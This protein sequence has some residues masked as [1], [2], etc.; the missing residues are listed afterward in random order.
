MPTIFLLALVAI[1]LILQAK[2]KSLEGLKYKYELSQNL[3][4]PDEI[5]ILITSLSNHSLR[6]IPFVKMEEA[7]PTGK[8]LNSTVYLMPRSKLVRKAPIS[9]PT[10]GRYLFTG[11]ILRGGDFLGLRE[12][13]QEVESPNELIVYPKPSEETQINK[14]ISGFL[15]DIS[16]RRFIIE[17]PI[18]TVGF[19]EYSGREPMKAISWPQS[20]RS[21]QLMVKTYD[22]SSELSASVVL[23][24]EHDRPESIENCLSIAHQVCLILEKQKVKY[25]FYSNILPE[26]ANN[27]WA[28]ISAG[29]GQG[30]LR[31]ILEGL[32]RA[33]HYASEPSDKL[34]ERVKKKESMIFITPKSE[35]GIIFKI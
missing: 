14:L 29:L 33:T 17:D 24:V 26:G 23:D 28:Y 16:V 11:A 12:S 8:T 5:F 21:G 6:F 22:Y 4:A 1:A 35:K 9:L 32:G 31:A 18:L 10:R 19:R 30:H 13:Y 20:A 15:G 7:L 34:L 27:R 3:V 2:N 25:D